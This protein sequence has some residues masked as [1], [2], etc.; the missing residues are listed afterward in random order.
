[1]TS[2]ADAMSPPSNLVQRDNGTDIS[3]TD[4]SAASSNG[5]AAAAHAPAA[6]PFM[7]CVGGVPLSG[8]ETAQ[9][10]H[11]CQLPRLITAQPAMTFSQLLQREGVHTSAHVSYSLPVSDSS[12]HASDRHGHPSNDT[13]NADNASH[14]HLIETAVQQVRPH[15]HRTSSKHNHT[16]FSSTKL[17]HVPLLPPMTTAHNIHTII[18]TQRPCFSIRFR[19]DRVVK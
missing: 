2:V 15:T 6:F 16:V 18:I 14:M 9:H 11:E 13:T 5:G 12:N 3:T 10:T 17:L 1:M 7:C 8:G 19:Y 4:N